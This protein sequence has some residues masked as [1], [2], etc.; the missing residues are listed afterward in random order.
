MILLLAY[1][2]I[3]NLILNLAIL[4]ILLWPAKTE[5]VIK[6]IKRL[7]DTYHTCEFCKKYLPDVTLSTDNHWSC[8]KCRKI[9]LAQ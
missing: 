5:P 4:F 9:V 6:T 7:G 3:A 2:T 8:S 1:T